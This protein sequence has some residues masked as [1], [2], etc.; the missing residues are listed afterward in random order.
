MIVYFKLEDLSPT[1][2]AWRRRQAVG[3]YKGSLKEL[4]NESISNRGVCRAAPG[5]AQVC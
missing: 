2:W 5:F 4:M 1:I 3:D